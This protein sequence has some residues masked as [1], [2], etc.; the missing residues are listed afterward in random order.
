M[1]GGDVWQLV[2]GLIVPVLLVYAALV[3]WSCSRDRWK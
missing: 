2:L 1:S 3:W